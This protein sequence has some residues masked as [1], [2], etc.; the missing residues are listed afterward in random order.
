VNDRHEREKSLQASEISFA[1]LMLSALYGPDGYYTKHVR[2]GTSGADF[3]TAAQS[4][5][6]AQTLARVAH[7]TWHSFGEPSR[8]Q[9]VEFG[10]GQGELAA[11]LLFA[12]SGLLPNVEVTYRIRDISKTLSSIQQTT[13]ADVSEQ[14]AQDLHL[15][16]HMD[17]P[18]VIFGNELLDAFPFERV[19][20]SDEG[21]L[22]AYVH[23][24][25]SEKTL[26]WRKA[27]PRIAAWADDFVGCP[28]GD[29][30]EVCLGYADFFAQAFSVAELA[31]LVL[32]DYGITKREW[33]SGV[34]PNGT[35]RAYRGHEFVD[36]L[37]NL[38]QADITADVNWDAAA[39]EAAA[40]GWQVQPLVTQG[41]FLINQGI[42]DLVEELSRT[43]PGPRRRQ[44]TNALKHLVLPGGMGERFAVLECQKAGRMGTGC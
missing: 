30:A 24:N 37:T 18:T 4:R 15:P 42:L 19:K 23:Q 35:L 40:A 1:R 10:G 28:V 25:A 36:V 6:F 9:V 22:Q 41:N 3:Y 14:A 5:L 43:V 21:W 11:G 26:I 2:I 38:G 33:Q 34:R 7:R 12:L 44:L 17:I 16:P 8:L 32:F 29:E 31:R 20:R 27:E 39:H 13:V